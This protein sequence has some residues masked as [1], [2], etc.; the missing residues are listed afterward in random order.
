M[1]LGIGAGASVAPDNYPVNLVVRPVG[2]PCRSS[3]RIAWTAPGVRRITRT[4]GCRFVALFP[5]EGTYRLKATLRGRDAV[6]AQGS[7]EVVVQDWLI[8]GLG[9]SNGSGEGAPDIAS[10]PL[11]AFDPPVW[12]DVR[13][14]RSANS[15][16]AQTARSIENRDPKTSVTFV[17]LACSGASIAEG[18]LGP[19]AGIN[20]G[21]TFAPQ[22][23][24]MRT[25]TQ[26]REIDA[27]L[28]SI[29]VNDLG[30]G[31]MVEHC[32]LYPSCMNKPF[33]EILASSTTL[34]E[35]MK[36]RLAALPG[37]YRKIARA[38]KDR[39]IPPGRVYISQYFDSTGYFD[40]AARKEKFCDPLIHIEVERLKPLAARLTHPF[41][42]ALV[43]A[44]G[45][46]LD[47]DRAEAEWA[48]REVLVPLNGRVKAAASK[49]GW[50]MAVGVPEL[51]RRHG[52]CAPEGDRWIVGLYE[53]FERQHDHNGTLHA[54]PYGN[55]QTARKTVP[56]LVQDL[57]RTGK[58]IRPRR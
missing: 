1:A 43:S 51:F 23:D 28:L 52:Y 33:P 22:V 45:P 13:C 7:E 12:H 29:G 24:G 26:G 39:K 32:I 37:G 49:Y 10:P 20:P 14:D 9:D 53:S 38:L 54:T 57:Y 41:L 58:G 5:T 6:G 34:D 11:P 44:V 4:G 8:V 50:R 19:Y 42:V 2:R 31:K 3:D 56:L 36:N 15:Y 40:R 16:Q 27:V 47:F 46:P 17:H 48:Q 30:F 18:I 25:L 55:A 21:A 35:V